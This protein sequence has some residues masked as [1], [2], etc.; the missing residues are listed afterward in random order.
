V[1]APRLCLIA[2]FCAG[3]S[4]VPGDDTEPKGHGGELAI[5]QPP[6]GIEPGTPPPARVELSAPATPKKPTPDPWRITSGVEKPTPDPWSPPGD[7]S[8]EEAPAGECQDGQENRQRA[9]GAP[10]R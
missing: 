2:L 8:A 7:C 4:G 10:A 1:S 9:A 6:E 5:D 3:C